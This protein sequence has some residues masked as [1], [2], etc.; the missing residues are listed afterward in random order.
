MALTALLKIA[1]PRWSEAETGDTPS[2]GFA[3]IRT[4]MSG[5]TPFLLISWPL[6]EKNLAVVKRT[7]AL[8]EVSGKTPCTLPLP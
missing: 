3:T 2:T 7:P 6:G 4:K 1:S 8:Q 5:E